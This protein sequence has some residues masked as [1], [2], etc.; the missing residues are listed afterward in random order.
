MRERERREREREKMKE[1]R[2]QTCDFATCSEIK[3]THL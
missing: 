2:N 3:G 1:K